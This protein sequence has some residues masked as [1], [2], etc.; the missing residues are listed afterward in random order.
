M[1]T[2]IFSNFAEGYAYDALPCD[3]FIA[4]SATNGH[5]QLRHM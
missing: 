2:K 4:V 1:G 3:L 5:E